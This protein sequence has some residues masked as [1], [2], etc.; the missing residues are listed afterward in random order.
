VLR[1]SSPGKVRFKGPARPKC[2]DWSD[3]AG[4]EACSSADIVRSTVVRKGRVLVSL[5][6]VFVPSQGGTIGRL[7]GIHSGN[8]VLVLDLPGGGALRLQGAILRPAAPV[9]SLHCDGSKGTVSCQDTF[10]AV[11]AFSRVVSHSDPSSLPGPPEALKEAACAPAQHAGCGEPFTAAEAR[12]IESS[13]NSSLSSDQIRSEAWS[14]VVRPSK[15]PREGLCLVNMPFTVSSTSEVA[16]ATRREPRRP[17]TPPMDLSQDAVEQS[18]SRPRRAAAPRVSM[19]QDYLEVSSD[20]PG[21]GDEDEPSPKR[22]PPPRVGRG[23]SGPVKHVEVSSGSSSGGESDEDEPSP[24]RSPPS[25]VGRG[26]SGPVKHVEVSSG[27]S[28]G[29]ESDEDE[30]SPK[31]SPPPRV[32]RGK[33]GPVKYAEASSAESLSEDSASVSASQEDSDFE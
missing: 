21:D 22:P 19:S 31:R 14:E 3:C 18:P 32:G 13:W 9:L 28:S 1:A 23:K 16:S 4:V 26:K 12:K 5:P 30:P 29:G 11:I 2:N 15:R 8:P 33:S 6:G 27:S 10:P 7:E 17:V 24:K 25:R 20:E